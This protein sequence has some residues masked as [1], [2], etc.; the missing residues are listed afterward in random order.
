MPRV[1]ACACAVRSLSPV[2]S[3][4]CFKPSSRQRARA[5]GTSAR[6]VSEA[7]SSP[8]TSPAC[9]TNSRVLPW[10]C[11]LLATSSSA[12]CGIMRALPT[13]MKAPFTSACT[14]NPGKAAKCTGSPAC[15]CEA[16]AYC[17]TASASGCSE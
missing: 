1:T 10:A 6:K 9:S 8:M 14:P 5:A 7:A 3:S 2:S 12:P 17:L 13:R 16:L 4:I 11:R 15:S